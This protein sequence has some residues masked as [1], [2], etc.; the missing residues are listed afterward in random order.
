MILTI[1]FGVV[2]GLVLW[3]VVLPI[4]L[5]LLFHPRAP[6]PPKPVRPPK[7][8]SARDRAVVYHTTGFCFGAL[9]IASAGAL[10][11]RWIGLL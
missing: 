1:A 11:A 3:H 7:L 4:A 2:L 9:G 8:P 5:V 10:I 6:K